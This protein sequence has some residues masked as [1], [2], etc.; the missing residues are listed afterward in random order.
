[1]T[2]LKKIA[3]SP[4]GL[5]RWCYLFEPDTKSKFADDKYKTDLRL[6]GKEAE[7]FKAILDDLAAQ[8]KEAEGS[9]KDVDPRYKTATDKDDKEID[10]AIDIKFKTK[11]PIQVLDGKK[12]RLTKSQVPGYK[13]N[14]M[15]GEGVVIFQP[16]AMTVSGTTHLVLYLKGV[17]I[18]ELGTSSIDLSEL[19][20]IE[21]GFVAD[22]A[23]NDDVHEEESEDE[24]PDFAAK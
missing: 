22:E 12:N 11:D 24:L 5:L 7:E 15:V 14:C 9:K 6:F 3:F 17:Q 19:D 1:M 23:V 16:E 18:R 20:E 13:P 10:G 8:A 21:D 2:K 4:Q